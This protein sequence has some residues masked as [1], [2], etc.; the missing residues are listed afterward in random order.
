MT[1]KLHLPPFITSLSAK[2]LVLTA[3]FVL[4]AEILIFAPSIG[5]FRFVSLQEQ[6]ADA[7]LAILALDATDDMMVSEDL[8]K[9]LLSHVNAL[10]VGLTRPGQGKLMLMDG[11]DVVVD[12]TYDLREESFFGLIKDAFVTLG[13]DRHRVLRIIGLSPKDPE[14]LVEVV[15]SETRLRMEMFDY[16]W[17]ILALSLGIALMTAALVFVSLHRLLVQPMRRITYS[18]IVFREAPEDAGRIIIPSRRTDEVGVAEQELASMQQSLQA[19]LG[20][21]NRLAAL[22]TAAA[23]INHDLRNGLATARLISDRLKRSDD[24]EVR[25][26]APVLLAAIDR[27]VHICG[28]MLNFTKEGTPR[29][30]ITNFDLHD[31]AS[32]VVDTIGAAESVCLLVQNHIPP[33]MEVSGD[34]EQLYRVFENL[35]RNAEQAGAS[36]VEIRMQQEPDCLI[37]TV[38][39]NGP[40]IPAEIQ[41]NLFKPFKGSTR[42]NGSGLGLAITRDLMRAHGGDIWLD[43][44]EL[45]GA[46]FCLE[47]PLGDSVTARSDQLFG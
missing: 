41:N 3:M 8:E 40:G 36:V 37:V 27:A 2:L 25:E 38:A 19:S 47:L 15:M 9:E 42:Q 22:G 20:Q 16:S 7:H 18:M 12:A 32:E 24:P 21:K 26:V 43:V 30:D 5:R 10:A 46:C 35:A 13:Q 44:S 29:L 1:P 31:L 45:G 11:A 28:Q 39:D 34:W 33:G 23:K 17:R 4:L 6:L 14:V